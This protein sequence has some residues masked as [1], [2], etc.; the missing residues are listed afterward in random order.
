[1]HSFVGSNHCG[2]LFGQAA[3][4][5]LRGSRCR[6]RSAVFGTTFPT[7]GCDAEFLLARHPARGSV[8]WRPASGISTVLPVGKRSKH[9][10]LD[11]NLRWRSGICSPDGHIHPRSVLGCADDG[12]TRR[13]ATAII[14][15][16]GTIGTRKRHRIVFGRWAFTSESLD[17]HAELRSACSR[18]LLR[19]SVPDG[20][21]HRGGQLPEI[22]G[23]RIWAHIR[24]R[25]AWRNVVPVGGGTAFASVGSSLR[26][27]GSAGWSRRDMRIGLENSIVEA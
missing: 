25:L 10:R 26:N 5:L 19:S 12:P 7:G 11:L 6:V 27:D 21:C 16:R 24:H 22:V 23:H 18:I 15:Q 20:A 9:R 8:S 2:T 14:H 17:S 4:I 3:V 13:G 1:M